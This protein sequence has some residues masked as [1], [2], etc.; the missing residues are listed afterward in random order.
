[1][2]SA[3][4]AQHLPPGL[5]MSTLPEDP[6]G[7]EP[8]PD[9]AVQVIYRATLAARLEEVS[10]VC[11]ELNALAL[12]RVGEQEA[13]EM[14]LG[15]AEALSNIVRHGYAGQPGA[16][17]ELVCVECRGR[18]CLRI[19]DRGRPV[20]EGLLRADTPPVF[21]FDPGALDEIPEGGMGLALMRASFDEVDYRAGSRGNLMVLT[22][23]VGNGKEPS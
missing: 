3:G 20:P 4:R 22:K 16:T 1:M 18:W 19:F 13:G 8:P 10:R 12:A 2:T 9:A 7:A 11:A 6:G 21:D 14:D 15:L 17:L 5:P 23:S